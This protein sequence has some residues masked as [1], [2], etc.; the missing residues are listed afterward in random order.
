[1][2]LLE[3]KIALITGA[4][5]GIG[6]SI[7][8]RFVQ[9]GATVAFTYRSSEE[10]AKALEDELTASG[11]TARGFKSDAGSLAESEALVT[12][13]VAA[14]GTVD[15]LINNAG[16]TRDTLLMR[17]SEEQWDDIMQVNLKSCFNLT[18]AVLRTMLKA[19]AGS[20]INMSSVVGIQGNAGQA[21]YA[22]SKAGILGFT[23]SVALELGSRNIR[24][25]AIAPGFIETEMTDALDEAT[26]QGWRD[27]IPLKRGGKPEDVADACVFLGSDMSGYITGQTLSV[28]G[29]MRM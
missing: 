11:G 10:K 2:A 18:K 5:R 16:I 25:N 19:R 6:K 4:S 23:K 24:C 8:Q 3:G 27:A 17:M 20:I 13:V 21:N 14:F 15:I 1:M 26:V 22:A 12:E 7:A 28:D 29:G 9:E